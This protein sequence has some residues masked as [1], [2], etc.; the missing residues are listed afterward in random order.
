MR[1][2][3]GHGSA[4]HKRNGC[5]QLKVIPVRDA[6]EDSELEGTL[7]RL[8]VENGKRMTDFKTTGMTG[9]WWK[10]L[11]T[12]TRCTGAPVSMQLVYWMG[13]MHCF[14]AGTHLAAHKKAVMFS[15]WATSLLGI[16]PF[17]YTGW[18]RGKLNEGTEAKT[19]KGD[20]SLAPE[21]EN[22]LFAR[23]CRRVT[24]CV[25]VCQT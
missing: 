12:H 23:F 10:E 22:K 20:F 8:G 24:E 25:C 13:L 18:G 4:G 15:I 3:L 2:G 6:H 9:G 16:H 11:H 19:G 17:L 5:S 14:P 1:N 21:S 7:K